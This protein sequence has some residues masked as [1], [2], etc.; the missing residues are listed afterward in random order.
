VNRT[1]CGSAHNSLTI[2]HFLLISFKFDILEKNLGLPDF[3][4]LGFFKTDGQLLFVDRDIL[5]DR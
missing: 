3:P 2:L 5:K 4:I 1:G